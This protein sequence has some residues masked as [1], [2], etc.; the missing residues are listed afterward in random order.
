MITTSSPAT[1]QDLQREVARIL[2]ECGFAVELEKVVVTP[3]GPVELD[4]YAEE[5]VKGRRYVIACECKHWAARIPQTVVHSF[6]TVVA[7]VGANVGY[8]VS[9]EGFQ[10]GSVRAS[11]MTNLQLVTWRSFQD[12][13]VNSWY[14]SFFVKEVHAHLKPLMSFT[15]YPFLPAW[16]ERMSEQDQ[17]DYLTLKRQHEL[18]GI[19]AQRLGPYRRMIQPNSPL[20]ELPLRAGLTG[21]PMVESVPAD[22]LDAIAYRDL[23]EA[24]MLHGMRAISEFRVYRDRY[25]A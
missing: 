1:W 19:V 4:V 12:L 6:R 2:V 25:A 17:A 9:M 23:L 15:E 22:V 24:A 20:P 18:F 11:E 5:T 16:W 21:D 10:S 14:D 7:E 3:R 13:F 8:L